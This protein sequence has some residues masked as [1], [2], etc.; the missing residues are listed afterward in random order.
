MNSRAQAL[1]R[2]LRARRALHPMMGGGVRKRPPKRLPVQHQP[3]AQR[4]AYYKALRAGPLALIRALLE[5]R[6]K[7]ALP[8]IAARGAALQVKHDHLGIAELYALAVRLDA[9]DDPNDIVD[10]M[11]DAY[12]EAFA[13]DR[14]AQVVQ[15]IGRAVNEFQRVQFGRQV[16]A[17]M[18]VDV[19]RAEPWLQPKIDAFVTENVSLVKSIGAE[20][21]PDLE[22]QLARGMLDGLRQEELA[23]MIEERYGVA[24]SRAALIARD[25]V[26][27]LFAGLNEARQADLGI[28]KYTW[29]TTGDNRVREEHAERDGEVYSWDDPPSDEDFGP[30]NPGE[31]INCRCYAEPILDDVLAEATGEDA[32]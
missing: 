12:A 24:E 9:D 10:E 15:P 26:G 2:E 29:R 27:K 25:Q 1:I 30:V 32:A 21:F 13:S 20:F 4:L 6:L 11:R 7:P 23:D 5:A 8:S 17:A 22:K 16:K 28:S 19:V 14:A 18:G 3:D 31:A